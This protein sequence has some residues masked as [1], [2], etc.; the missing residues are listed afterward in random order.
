[1]ADEFVGEHPAHIFVVAVEYRVAWHHVIY[2]V[3]IVKDNF[4]RCCA[5]L[6]NLSPLLNPDPSFFAS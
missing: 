6:I 5:Q 3:I 1:V 4:S 2:H